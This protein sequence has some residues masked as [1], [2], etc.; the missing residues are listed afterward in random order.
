MLSQARLVAF[1]ATADAARARAFYRD[2]LG[3]RLVSDEAFAVVFDAHG[4]QLRVTIAKEVTPAAYTVLGWE[5]PDIAA[6]IEALRTRG[7]EFKR[8]PG[9]EQD[10]RA[11]WTAPGGTKVA[12]FNDPDGNVLSLAQ[13]P[14]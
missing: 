11:V 13:H 10:A 4:T 3:L 8:Y 9:L 7:V 6:A 14:H 5:V 1:V 12:W 2:T